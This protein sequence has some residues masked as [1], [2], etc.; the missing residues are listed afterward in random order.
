MAVY[1]ENA[2]RI[3]TAKQVGVDSSHSIVL[4]ITNIEGNDVTIPWNRIQKVGEVVLLGT[5]TG[6]AAAPSGQI[7]TC[8]SCGFVNKEGSKFCEECG[9][10]I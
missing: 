2:K 6:T 4:I 5:P 9:I 8:H 10:E 1:D 3:G 7:G